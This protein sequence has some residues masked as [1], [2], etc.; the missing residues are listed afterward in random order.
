MSYDCLLC[1]PSLD[2]TASLTTKCGETRPRVS[3]GLDRRSDDITGS[4]SGADPV[5]TVDGPDAVGSPL[6]SA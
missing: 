4:R 3:G 2:N 5:D 6:G 1:V